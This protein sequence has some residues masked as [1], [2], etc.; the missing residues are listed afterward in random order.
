MPV[1]IPL[2]FRILVDHPYLYRRAIQYQMSYD[3]ALWIDL[4]PPTIKCISLD[5]RVQSNPHGNDSNISLLEC[6]FTV[7]ETGYRFLRLAASHDL[8]YRFTVYDFSF[9]AKVKRD[10]HGQLLDVGRDDG[11]AFVED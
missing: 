9:S 6:R 8:D 2:R 3:G 11:L 4:K 10:K 1:R 5:Q 7:P